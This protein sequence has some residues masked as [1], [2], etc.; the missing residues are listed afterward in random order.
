M[1]NQGANAQLQRLEEQ[2]LQLEKQGNIL[3]ALDIL[4]KDM[5]IEKRWYHLYT[6]ACWLYE[7][8]KKDIAEMWEVVQEGFSRFP[9]QRFWFLYIRADLRYRA[10][11]LSATKSLQK[12]EDSLGQL[13]E[14]QNDIASAGYELR[15]RPQIVKETL[16]N[17]PCLLPSTWHKNEITDVSLKLDVLR[18]SINAYRQQI[19]ISKLLRVKTRSI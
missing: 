13:L 2:A 8:P 15:E 10:V 4:E 17:P 7:L 6:K 11:V 12:L 19:L 18:N 9:D 14:A 5:E 16:D 1:A 3:G